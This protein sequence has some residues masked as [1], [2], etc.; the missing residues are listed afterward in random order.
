MKARRVS[1]FSLA[2]LVVAMAMAM[3][4]MA[5]GLPYFL[6]AY[7]SYQLS[8]AATQMA[9]ILRLTRYEA[10]R[11][12]KVA[13]CLIRPDPGDPTMTNASMTDANGNALTGLGSRVVLLGSG[14]NLVNPGSVP[15]ASSLPSAAALGATT[16]TAIPPGGGTVQ[17]DARGAV[18]SGNVTVV[19]LNAAGSP[20]SGYRAVLLMPSGSIQIWTGDSTG[21]WQQLR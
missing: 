6:R 7:R 3:I 1:G 16:P 13:A 21:S 15:G 8:S 2:E 14:G 5:V 20:E 12:N 11:L 10:I 19:Y 18:T 17:F 9:D 4:L